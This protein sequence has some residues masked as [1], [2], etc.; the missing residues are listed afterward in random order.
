MALLFSQRA[1]PVRRVRAFDLPVTESVTVLSP[2]SP[3]SPAPSVHA[4]AAVPLAPAPAVLPAPQSVLEARWSVAEQQLQAQCH[5]LARELRALQTSCAQQHQEWTVDQQ[6]LLETNAVLAETIQTLRQH[7]QALG[8]NNK[9]LAEHLECLPARDEERD[10]RVQ[11][12]RNAVEHLEVAHA[13][14]QRRTDERWLSVDT[15]LQQLDLE[16]NGAS[17]ASFG[18]SNGDTV[19]ERRLAKASRQRATCGW[20]TRVVFLAP[21]VLAAAWKVVG[22]SLHHRGGDAFY[23]ELGGVQSFT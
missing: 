15:V 7:I 4:D 10:Q 20:V 5:T 17:S 8:E 14:L 18:P 3:S 13:S 12:L 11:A 16:A 22:W 2:P 23:P 1:Q 19:E 6:G 21:L 9:A